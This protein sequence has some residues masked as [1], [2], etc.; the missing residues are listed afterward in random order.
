MFKGVVYRVYR[1]MGQKRGYGMP[2]RVRVCV[3]ALLHAKIFIMRLAGYGKKKSPAGARL[4][5]GSKKMVGC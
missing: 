2:S 3:A 1:Q 4:F 5:G